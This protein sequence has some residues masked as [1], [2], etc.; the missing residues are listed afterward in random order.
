MAFELFVHYR[1]VAVHVKPFPRI[2]S[3]ILHEYR[4]HKPIVR[5]KYDF[6]IVFTYDTFV[7]IQRF[8]T[9]HFK[10]EPV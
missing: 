6:V 5:T 9:Q 2:H 8:V 7:H 10:N 1:P 3:K 4:R